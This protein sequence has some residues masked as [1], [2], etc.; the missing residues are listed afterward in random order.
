L[1]K[2]IKTYDRRLNPIKWGFI[3]FSIIAHLACA[4]QSENGGNITDRF[5]YLDTLNTL[6]GNNPITPKK[7]AL[8]RNLFFD[9]LLSKNK[10]LSCASCHDQ[11][12]A[13]SDGV[14]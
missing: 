7:V 13:F 11:A 1:N 4:K 12:H 14:A 5:L 2:S 9:P 8:G 3:G 6:P 10:D